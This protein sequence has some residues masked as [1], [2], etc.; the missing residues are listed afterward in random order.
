MTS[1][2]IPLHMIS[3]INP[4]AVNTSSIDLNKMSS[5]SKFLTNAHYAL[6]IGDLKQFR[7]VLYEAINVSNKDS[8]LPIPSITVIDLNLFYFVLNE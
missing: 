6:S 1:S 4:V 3:G 2:E 8:L 5:L 7:T